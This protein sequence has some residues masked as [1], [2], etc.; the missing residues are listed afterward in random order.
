MNMEERIFGTIQNEFQMDGGDD[1]QRRTQ[2][3][4]LYDFQME[5]LSRLREELRVLDEQIFATEMAVVDQSNLVSAARGIVGASGVL[6]SRPVRSARSTARAKQRLWTQHDGAV[7]RH[8]NSLGDSA[9]NSATTFSV[10]AF[11]MVYSPFHKRF[12]APRQSLIAHASTATVV[13][14][15]ALGDLVHI[16]YPGDRVW[17]L[18]W[19][20]RNDGLWRNFVRPPR[21]KQ[22]QR[23]GVFATRS[24][25]RPSPIGLS[26]CTV[27]RKYNVDESVVLH[28][29]GADMLDET[30]VISVRKYQENTE[31]FPHARAGWLDDRAAVQPLYYDEFSDDDV[32]HS[33]I[34][35]FDFESSE[36][37]KFIQNESP[38][39]VF[40]M[41]RQSLR[42]VMAELLTDVQNVGITD[43]N[44]PRRE[45]GSMALGAFRVSYEIYISLKKVI[46]TGV[47]SGMRRSVCEEEANA[48]PEASLH[49][50][51]QNKYC[52]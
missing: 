6:V 10:C 14:V 26:L 22:G 20:D 30:P 8:E 21:S 34:V 36:K 38:I 41:V 19:L 42:R 1:D 3:K 37:L 51:F 50:S 16:L 15:G 33:V 18:Y 45:Y 23:T 29:S 49:L 52:L 27:D 9:L 35:E 32:C 2:I 48:D 13:L 4:Q 17:L 47:T 40:V 28:V 39:D 24:P 25:N 46:V 12:E 43:D 7:V 5:E 31:A 11:G 44:L